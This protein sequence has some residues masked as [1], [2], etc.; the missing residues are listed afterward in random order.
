[1]VAAAWRKDMAEL[2]KC[3]NV[4]KRGGVNMMIDD[5][6]WHEHTKLPTSDEMVAVA[7]A[8]IKE[9]IDLF[10]NKRGMPGAGLRWLRAT[11][12]FLQEAD[13]GVLGRGEGAAVS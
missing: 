12:E 10:D 9:P 3:E 4:V 2:A 7:G 13:A 1:M 11:V 5:H 8:H 6:G